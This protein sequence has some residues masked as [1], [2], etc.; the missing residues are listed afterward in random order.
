[1]VVLTLKVPRVIK[2]KLGEVKPT[3]EQV[4]AERCRDVRSPVQG[5]WKLKEKWLVSQKSE[6]TWGDSYLLGSGKRSEVG[7][8]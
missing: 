2:Q 5:R 6:V 7:A 3:T 1:M 4:E 8:G